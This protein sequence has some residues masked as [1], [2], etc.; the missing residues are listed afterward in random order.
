MPLRTS[1][2][3]IAFDGEREVE[4]SAGE[5]LF[6]T[7]CAEGPYTIDVPRTLSWAAANG[8]LKATGPPPAENF[9]QRQRVHADIDA[10][11]VSPT[12]EETR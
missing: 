4:I 8:I 11:P 6:A 3:T 5:R 10:A 2:G 12:Q 9:P 7:L 1:T